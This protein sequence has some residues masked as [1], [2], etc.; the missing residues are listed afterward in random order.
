MRLQCQ[1]FLVIQ[2]S[3]KHFY[4]FLGPHARTHTHT[5]R[6]GLMRGNEKAASCNALV[7]ACWAGMSAIYMYRCHN[8]NILIY[9]CR[10]Q[11]NIFIHFVSLQALRYAPYP[12]RVWVFVSND[13]IYT[14]CLHI[15]CRDRL[16]IPQVCFCVEVYYIYIYIYCLVQPKGRHSDIYV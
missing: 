3:C 5:H 1:F 4:S 13:A 2:T 15:K 8:I 16:L 12:W 11:Y 6:G 9:I 14:Y 10:C 7:L